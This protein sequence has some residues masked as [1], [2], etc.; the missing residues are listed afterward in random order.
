[1]NDG[2]CHCG[3]GQ[4]APISPVSHARHGYVKGQPRRYINGHNV[5]PAEIRYVEQ[6]C[7][8]ET[9]CWVWQLGRDIGG[10]GS[11]WVPE[12]KKMRNAHR[13]Y[14]ERL[15]GP[16]PEGLQLDHLCRNRACVNP[17][18]LEPVTAAEN[19]RRSSTQ[20]LTPEDVRAL[21]ESDEGSERI[22]KRYGVDG[23]RV[24]QLRRAAKREEA[25]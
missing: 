18:H 23:S 11:V 9:P 8:Y 6:D 20:K 2:L 22:A 16:V 14:Y 7:G 4:L 12:L 24:R 21:V 13:V 10:Y 25:A 19:V 15:V 5:R 17:M 3:C 1:M